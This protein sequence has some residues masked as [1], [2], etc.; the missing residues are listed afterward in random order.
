MVRW[1]FFI[2]LL[3]FFT[4]A[5]ATTDNIWRKDATELQDLV[6]SRYAYLDRLE[7]Q[8]FRL[9]AKLQS[10]AERVDNMSSLLTFAERALMLLA[11]HHAITG[12]SFDDSWA[13]V[14][15]YSDL[16]IE[17]QDGEYRISS[18]R[19]GSPAAASSISAGDRLIK[20][21]DT[22]TEEAVRTFWRELGVEGEIGDDRAGYAARILAA[23]RRDR[24]RRITV[25]FAGG[26]ES[27]ELT[28]PTLYENQPELPQIETA[29]EHQALRIVFNDGLDDPATVEAF[30]IVMAGAKKGQTVILDLTNTPSGGNTV[31]AR[32]IMGWF[33]S[34]AQYYQIHRSPEEERET[35]IARQWVE[36]VLPRGNGKYHKGKV[37]VRVGRWTGSMG[38][39]LAIGFAALGARVTG[40][41]MAG[42]LGAVDDLELPNSKLVIQLP[43][44]RLYSVNGMPREDFKPKA[45]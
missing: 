2:L 43:V 6:N 15:T 19:A 1:S 35:T 25:R 11:D 36:Q 5:F 34:E 18:V 21:G 22:N 33:V 38:E 37:I 12:S 10:E 4:P 7:G 20:I 31:I 23:G 16:W 26:A 27:R 39:G 9:T 42:L 29:A 40:E 44:E 41:R 17:R 13:L 32:A 3:L 30:D 14:P 28:L 24:I 8:K 45:K